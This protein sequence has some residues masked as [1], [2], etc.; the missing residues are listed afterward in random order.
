MAGRQDTSANHPAQAVRVPSSAQGYTPH[1]HHHRDVQGGAARAAV[2]G[3]SDGLVT[4]VSLIL[5]MAGANPTAGVVRLAGLLGLVAGAFSMATGEYVS[6]R[7]QAELLARELEMERIEIHRRPENERRELAAIYRSRG[8]DAQ[9]ADDL[10][11]EMHRDPDLAL[12]THA[13]EEL[14][15]NPN[16]LGSPVQA[17]V[18]SFVAFSGGA[19]VSLIPW[20]FVSGSHHAGAV[21]VLASVVLAAVAAVIVGVG[22]ARFTGRSA[23]RS[24]ARQLFISGVAAGATFLA[25]RFAG[26]HLTL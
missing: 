25:G 11:T 2:F 24:A 18:S 21:T 3:V 17:A 15:I 4:N 26:S 16:S 1:E 12:E 9:V 13:R 20:F 7:A 8:V 14:G 19:L 5:G 23:I 22:L 6:M 10:A